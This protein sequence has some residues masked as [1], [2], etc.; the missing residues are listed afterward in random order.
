MFE[1]EP[2]LADHIV[3]VVLNKVDLGALPKFTDIG[4]LER[5]AYRGEGKEQKVLEA[6]RN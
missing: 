6:A 5:F 2:E 3:G 4:G 1:R